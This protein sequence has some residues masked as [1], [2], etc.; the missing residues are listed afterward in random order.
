MVSFW[1]GEQKTKE[2]HRNLQDLGKDCSTHI[3]CYSLLLEIHQDASRDVLCCAVRAKAIALAFQ[4]LMVR[5]HQE[6]TLIVGLLPDSLSM[7]FE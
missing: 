4:L 5:G 6:A 1:H 3:P 7:L 2:P